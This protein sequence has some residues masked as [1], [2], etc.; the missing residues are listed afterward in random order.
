MNGEGFKRGGRNSPWPRWARPVV[1]K[2]LKRLTSFPRSRP[3][4]LKQGVNET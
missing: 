4:Q 2:P 1:R 3:T